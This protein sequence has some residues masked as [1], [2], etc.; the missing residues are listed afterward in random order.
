MTM[1]T[2][3]SAKK[4][5]HGTKMHPRMC[6]GAHKI[7]CVESSGIDSTSR[8]AIAV[9]G[10]I[11]SIRLVCKNENAAARKCQKSG[12]GDRQLIQRQPFGVFRR[13]DRR[14]IYRPFDAD[15]RIVPNQA[16]IMFRRVVVCCLVKKI[17]QSDKTTKPWAKPE[18]SITGG[19]CLRKVRCRPIDRMW[20]M[21]CAYRRRHRR[22]GL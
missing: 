18:V 11:Q 16:A 17:R 20:V 21:I 8:T 9:H 14:K 22:R 2:F 4:I 7:F 6:I 19:D 1:P 12:S 5:P 13:Q 10:L 15:R 3:Q